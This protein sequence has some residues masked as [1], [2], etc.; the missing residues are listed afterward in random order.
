LG[1]ARLLKY[2]G[3]AWQGQGTKLVE[4]TAQLKDVQL[5]HCTFD[6][7]RYLAFGYCAAQVA[8]GWGTVSHENLPTK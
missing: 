1:R 4:V 7:S 6:G 5:I 2:G 3:N 8:K